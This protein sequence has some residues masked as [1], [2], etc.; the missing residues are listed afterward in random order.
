[1]RATSGLR[2]NAALFGVVVG[3]ATS[4]AQPLAE[5]VP[6]PCAQDGTCPA[7]LACVPGVGCSFAALDALCGPETDCGPSGGVC[8]L[9]LCAAACAGGC[10]AGRVCSAA[11]GEGVCLVDCTAGEACPEH[12]ACA[13]LWHGGKR[14]CVP[15]SQTFAAC[16]SSELEAPP[17]CGSDGFTVQCPSGGRCAAHSTC[18][19][20]NQCEC[21]PGYVPW[22][23]QSGGSCASASCAFPNWWCLPV[24]IPGACAAAGTWAPG[25]WRCTDGRVLAPRCGTDCETAC[26]EEGWACEPT[27]QTCLEPRASRCTLTTTGTG[28]VGTA[29]VPAT[30]AGLAGAPC[31]RDA[32]ASPAFDDC[33]AGHVC[34]MLGEPGVL[35]CHRFC[36]HS[37]E[38]GGGACMRISDRVPPDGVC[39]SQCELFSPCRD[40][41]TCGVLRDVDDRVVS[42]C[43]EQ[44]P[45]AVVDTPCVLQSDCA[46]GL[47]C[48]TLPGGAACRPL[49]DATHPCPGDGECVAFARSELPAGTG[50]CR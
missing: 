35:T 49:C 1:M 17:V 20:N 23:C 42:Q 38:C 6:F 36:A 45:A 15:P 18:L 8:Q 32:G 47:M 46:D 40:G 7:G 25:A 2:R 43:R 39:V 16:A 14:G 31:T 41:R 37:S 4:C 10:G 28:F 9:G 26:R 34:S 19:P 22:N 24:G 44:V 29:C 48:Q 21:E 50:F 5:L 11:G 27:R 13:P 33:A 12:L 3:F 30:G